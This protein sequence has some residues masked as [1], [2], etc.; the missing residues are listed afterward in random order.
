MAEISQNVNIEMLEKLPDGTYRKKNPAT[1]AEVVKL[2][3]A[4]NKFTNKN[5]EGAM[6][7]L[8]T[9][10]S[11]GKDL[12]GGAI[13]G[14]DDSVVIPTDPTFGDLASAIGNISTGKK[15]A[16][17][18]TNNGSTDF[19]EIS[20]LGFNPSLV[21]AYLEKPNTIQRM[22]VSVSTFGDLFPKL[23]TY[24]GLYN[25]FWY[26]DT[27]GSQRG[28]GRTTTPIVDGFKVYVPMSDVDWFWI[29]FE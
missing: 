7:E 18:I 24:P 25:A 9:N 20:N 22:I 6:Q 27:R 28:G 17:G 21:V 11:S 29:A 15:W 23:G 13:T 16:S 3:D 12:V 4:Q 19:L 8:F 10:V 14:V 2:V 5:V 26:A 1:K